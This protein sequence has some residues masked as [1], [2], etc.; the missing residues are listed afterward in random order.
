MLYNN[1]ISHSFIGNA[2][3]D[4]LLN[5][6]ISDTSSSYVYEA[7]WWIH[8]VII[9]GFSVY[10]PISKHVHLVGAPIAFVTRQLD[11]KGTLTTI[12]DF[13][14]AESFGA[15]QMK[16][17]NQKQLLDAFAC[18]VCGRCTDVCP[19]NLTGKTLSP[20]H[21]VPHSRRHLS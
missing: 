15:S 12:T 20:M 17:F 19:A 3:G 14:E 21:V 7:S 8:L 5:I 1:I 11:A 2:L 18:A 13:E 4:W 16:D 6:G 10:I 9:L